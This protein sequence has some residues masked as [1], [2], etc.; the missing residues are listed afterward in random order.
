MRSEE[1]VTMQN[2]SGRCLLAVLLLVAVAFG[3]WAGQV[4]DR[5]SHCFDD[6][7]PAY[8]ANETARNAAC[9]N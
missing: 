4:N 9:G 3:M 1:M 8:I 2:L 6:Y 5:I 7:D